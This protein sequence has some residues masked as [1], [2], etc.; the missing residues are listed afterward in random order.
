MK[1]GAGGWG[2]YNRP[3]DRRLDK[4][5]SPKVWLIHAEEMILYYLLTSEKK[6]KL[7]AKTEELIHENLIYR[8]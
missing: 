8:K 1:A 2:P 6:I 4:P 3:G 7:L 5:D